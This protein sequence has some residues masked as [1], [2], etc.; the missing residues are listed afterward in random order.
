[1]ELVRRSQELSGDGNGA[2]FDDDEDIDRLKRVTEKEVL[3]MVRSPEHVLGVDVEANEPKEPSFVDP[4]RNPMVLHANEVLA[5]NTVLLHVYDLH[6]DL[7]ETNGYL[8][9]S[10][11]NF[12]MGGLFH[13]GVEV[14]GSEW[15]YG[16]IGVC[17]DPPRT[18]EAHEYRCSVV[19]AQT[20]L[21]SREVAKQVYNL[22]QT[23]SGK[24]YDLISRNC[25]S[26]ATELCQ[27]LGVG[28]LPPWVDRFA[29][30]LDHGKKLGKA[31]S[32]FLNEEVAGYAE[33][34]KDPNAPVPPVIPNSAD[35]AKIQRAQSPDALRPSSPEATRGR[36]QQVE[37][38][39]AGTA[40]DSPTSAGTKKTSVAA[41]LAGQFKDVQR[42]VA[43]GR[44]RST[45]AEPPQ[46]PVGSTVELE[47][48]G[49]WATRQV[50][51][52]DADMGTY[53]VDGKRQVLGGKLRWPQ[54]RPPSNE[55]SMKRRSSSRDAAMRRAPSDNAI[56]RGPSDVTGAMRRAPSEKWEAPPE[57]VQTVHKMM[58]EGQFR[59]RRRRKRGC[60]C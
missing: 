57:Q 15:S 51:G 52:Y 44:G 16:Y 18:L 34:K 6:E 56:R 28:A 26:F 4:L 53:D 60:G 58:N 39:E 54:Q 47:E 33:P 32:K 31:F 17:C 3:I 1:M 50:L 46:Y 10:L 41:K 48:N 36:S 49:V 9:F 12:A 42:R 14:F 35:P 8:A 27:C 19:M 25:C 30:L 59:T 24:E 55:R 21:S 7:Q 13:V 2:C 20:E 11:D 40:V 43:P 23:W 37:G 38:G 45:S 29:R 5:N 22:C